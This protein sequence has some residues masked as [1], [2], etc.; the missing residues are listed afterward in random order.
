[1][2]TKSPT[3]SDFLRMFGTID[4]HRA[5]ESIGSEPSFDE[6]EVAMAYLADMTDVM[7]E[8]RQP[9]FR[10]AAEIYE[11]VIRDESFEEE[12]SGQQ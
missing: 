11:I 4:D 7:G 3:H 9:L 8:E 2:A 6:L 10:N 1:M 12:E 5:L